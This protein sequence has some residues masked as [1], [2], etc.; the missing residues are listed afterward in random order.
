MKIE[1]ILEK[2]ELSINQFISSEIKILERGLNELNFNR[3]IANFIEPLFDGYDVDTEY[4][5]DIDKLNDRKALEIAQNEMIK[6]GIK[7]NIKNYYI[8]N[9][10]IIIHTRESNDNNL[11][12]LEIKKDSNQKKRKDFDLLKLKHLTINYC[13]NHYN[14]KLGIALVFGTK[15]KA[16]T[17]DIHFFQNGIKLE[18]EELR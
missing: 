2:I 7:H 3:K 6:I 15:E 16:G 5:G 9:P 12:V 11:V 18:K 10:D 4:N 17:Y 14:Y 8:I 13:E 1:L